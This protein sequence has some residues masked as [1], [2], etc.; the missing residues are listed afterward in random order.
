MKQYFRREAE[1]QGRKKDK[2][3]QMLSN[4]LKRNNKKTEETKIVE[5]FKKKILSTI[6]E[7]DKYYSPNSK[8]EFMEE[9]KISNRRGA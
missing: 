8:R 4:A 7:S 1:T 5:E 6:T 3:E 9:N 2:I